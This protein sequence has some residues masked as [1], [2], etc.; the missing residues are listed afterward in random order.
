MVD[1][2]QAVVA[3]A[4][5]CL[6]ALAGCT[7]ASPA[8]PSP[9]P[10]PVFQTPAETAQERQERL[11]Y[12]AAEKAYRTFRSEYNRVLRAGG[13]K[14][15]TTLMSATAG[16]SYLA[17]LA[18]VARAYDG[19][20]AHN[21]GKEQIRYV[22]HVGYGSH[23][24]LLDVCEDGRGITTKTRKEQ[25]HG[26]IRTARLKVRKV[27]DKWKVWTGSGQKVNTCG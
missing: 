16:G 24:L 19:V 2:R 11:D 10:S 1:A 20:G 22:R 27:D 7:P 4:A 12:A 13:A 6:L 5:A 9:T 3:V 23:E 15:P 21:A 17:E 25:L 18:R 8:A 14:K 26:E